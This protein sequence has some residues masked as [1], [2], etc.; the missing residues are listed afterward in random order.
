MKYTQSAKLKWAIDL[1]TRFTSS[2]NGEP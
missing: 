2:A 1:C